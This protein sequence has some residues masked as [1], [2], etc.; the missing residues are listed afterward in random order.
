M[1]ALPNGPVKIIVGAVIG[2]GLLAALYMVL[3]LGWFLFALALLGIEAWSFFNPYANDTISEVIWALSERPLVP[4]MFGVA[5]GWSITSG[6]IPVTH[7]GQWVIL[8]LGTLLGHFFWR[9][10]GE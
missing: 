2:L 6:I 4:L 9:P 8:F 3:P 1:G 5:T 7:E 10:Q